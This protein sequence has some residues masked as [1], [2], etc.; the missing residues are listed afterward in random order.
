M[1]IYKNNIYDEERALY[2]IHDAVV[3]NCRF[4]GPADGESALKETSS[5]TIKNC[6]F[7]LRYP[8]WHTSDAFI[9]NCKMTETC[10]A[11]LWYD[12]NVVIKNSDLGGIKAVRECEN[13]E[14]YG[15]DINSTEFGW[16]C[17]N[18]KVRDCELVSEYPF[19]KTTG[20][21]I[22]NLKMHG[23]YSFQYTE[24]AEIHNSYLD[25]K[26]AF[27]HG[28]NITVYDSVVKGE[29]LGW[30]SENIKFVRCRI[31]G[32]QPLCYVKN[33][34]LEDCEMIDCDLSFEKSEVT[35]DIKGNITSVKNPVC[36]SITADVIE[37]VIIDKYGK[38]STCEIFE[39]QPLKKEI[40]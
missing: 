19:L 11:A 4:E 21:K 39:R 37:E 1:T 6:N 7:L 2:G 40:H 26:D 25:T 30:Y 24:N 10:R 27:W 22:D 8:L 13:I 12:K 33:L 23:K 35:A 36:G 28:R 20:L 14:I 32:T 3:E 16:M 9:E 18:L 34:T 17:R 31:I 5:L 38:D 15:T 29:Y